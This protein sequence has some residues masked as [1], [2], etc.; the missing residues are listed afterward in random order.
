MLLVVSGPR[1]T[2]CQLSACLHTVRVRLSEKTE[3]VW[4][5]NVYRRGNSCNLNEVIRGLIQSWS[6]LLS[7]MDYPFLSGAVATN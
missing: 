5:S 4:D 7:L 2:C 1:Q 6:G 3:F